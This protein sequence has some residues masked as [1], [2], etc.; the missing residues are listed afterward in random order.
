MVI[1]SGKPA[2]KGGNVRIV[3]WNMWKGNIGRK[4][5]TRT[6]TKIKLL[7]KSLL[8]SFVVIFNVESHNIIF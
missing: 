1:G 5:K 6:G 8:V 7:E 2:G 4:M 3:K